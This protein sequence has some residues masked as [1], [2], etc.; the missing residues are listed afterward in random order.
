MA[1]DRNEWTTTLVSGMALLTL[2]IVA[3]DG[4]PWFVQ[5]PYW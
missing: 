4:A 1:G 3:L 2:G 5:Y